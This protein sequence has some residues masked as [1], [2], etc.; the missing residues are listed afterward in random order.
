MRQGR[1]GAR[2][3]QRQAASDFRAN[4]TLA[5]GR[6]VLKNASADDF[7][8]IG[9]RLVACGPANDPAR[10]EVRSALLLLLGSRARLHYTQGYSLRRQIAGL[11][12]T[13]DE[14]VTLAGMVRVTASFLPDAMADEPFP[15]GQ[16]VATA[17]KLVS[18]DMVAAYIRGAL[19]QPQ[20]QHRTIRAIFAE[21]SFRSITN[22]SA[23]LSSTRGLRGYPGAGMSA[24]Y[25]R[26]AE[27]YRAFIRQAVEVIT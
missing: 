27:E 10:L 12:H 17:M 13:P 1:W 9:T 19:A 15:V 4:L 5:V 16:F 7:L 6:G 21:G 2:L 20:R 8:A 24:K 26:E 22:S 14:L 23:F 11:P 18:A 3:D 25:I